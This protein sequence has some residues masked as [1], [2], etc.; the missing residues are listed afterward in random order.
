M[1]VHDWRALVVLGVRR[2]VRGVAVHVHVRRGAVEDLR[3]ATDLV[4]GQGGFWIGGGTLSRLSRGESPGKA[5]EGIAQLLAVQRV[6]PVRHHLIRTGVTPTHRLDHHKRFAPRKSYPGGRRGAGTSVRSSPAPD[7]RLTE[8]VTRRARSIAESL[9]TQLRSVP[10][11]DPARPHASKARARSG[12]A[13]TSEIAFRFGR[14]RAFGLKLVKCDHVSWRVAQLA[15]FA[16]N[17][18]RPKRR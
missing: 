14:V 5:P 11:T 6:V 17:F 1:R 13:N 10:R 16:P 7:D 8:R 12:A 3:H 4:I 9:S 18:I 15:N 2:V